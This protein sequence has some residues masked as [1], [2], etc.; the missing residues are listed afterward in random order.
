MFIPVNEILSYDLEELDVSSDP[1]TAK[2]IVEMKKT[3]IIFLISFLEGT[4]NPDI[5]NLLLSGLQWKLL[6]WIFDNLPQK[7]DLMIL[8]ERLQNGSAS[9]DQE[10]GKLSYILLLKLM[11]ND[12]EGE[13]I[14]YGEFREENWWEWLHDHL[15]KFVVTIEVLKDGSLEKVKRFEA[16]RSDLLP[17]S[18]NLS[19]V[20]SNKSISRNER[21]YLL[22][23][24]QRN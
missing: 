20:L 13:F 12:I 8:S 6:V 19:Q 9:K 24:Q 5:T 14:D 15:K 17:S 18:R 22:Q 1:E 10:L 7:R 16:N 11:D 2:L 3:C 23:C 21:E 4:A